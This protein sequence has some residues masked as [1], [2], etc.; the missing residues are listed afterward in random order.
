MNAVAVEADYLS[1]LV[2][3]AA[4]GEVK[5]VVAPDINFADEAAFGKDGQGAVNGGARDGAVNGAGSVEKALCR[6]VVGVI[7]RSVKDGHALIGHAQSLS[8]QI[9]PKGVSGRF[10]FLRIGRWYIHDK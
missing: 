6:E 9:V 8:G 5:F 4:V 7:V 10:A 1:E 2:F 3:P